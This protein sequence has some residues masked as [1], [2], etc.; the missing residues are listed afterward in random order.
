MIKSL[1]AGKQVEALRHRK[2]TRWFRHYSKY[3][4]SLIYCIIISEYLRCF[5][6]KYN[7]ISGSVEDVHRICH[8]FNEDEITRNRK[9]ITPQK[10]QL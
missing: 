3:S 2:C 9:W 6:N 4:T 7:S 8:K 1:K 10:L 5:Q